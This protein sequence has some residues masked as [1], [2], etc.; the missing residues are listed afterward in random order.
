MPSYVIPPDNRAVGTGNPPQDVNELSDME[1]LL[2]AVV[3]QWG[4]YPGNTTIPA[5]NAANVTALQALLGGSR[6]FSVVPPPSGDTSGVTDNA[7]WTTALASGGLVIVPDPGASQWYVTGNIPVPD[8]TVL[9]G[10][11][12]RANPVIKLVNSSGANCVFGSHGYLNGATSSGYP[13]I[14]R[15][16]SI[17]VNCANNSGVHGIILMTFRGW[18][19]HCYVLNAGGAA[20][21]FTDENSSGGTIGN[22]AVENRCTHNEAYWSSPAATSGQYGIWVADHSTGAVTDGYML[23]NIVGGPGDWGIYAQRA[24]GWWV[25]GNHVYSAQGSG[26]YF[27]ATWASAIHHNKVAAF[28]IAGAASTTYFGFDVRCLANSQPGTN[29]RP[30]HFGHNSATK[31]ESGDAASTVN[32]YFRARNDTGA[33]TATLTWDHNIAHQDKSGSGTSTAWLFDANGATL[34]LTNDGNIADGPNAVPVTSGTVNY[35]APSRFMMASAQSV[36]LGVSSS[37]GTA[38]NFTP[39]AFSLGFIPTSIAMVWGGSFSSDTV[40]AQIVATYSDGTTNTQT[41]GNITSAQT[42]SANDGLRYSLYKNGVYLTQLA[43]SAR[44]NQGS[45]SVTLSAEVCGFNAN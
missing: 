40:N 24:S 22:T 7:A 2:A 29:G 23:D 14:V 32:R 20:F 25:T 16:L 31:D 36:T 38:V 44:T 13:V 10:P 39:A 5:S 9:L 45:T 33:G 15:N 26:A 42:Q 28:G 35:R 17:D 4:G 3:A 37:Y 34:D 12:F 30:S 6:P 21:A 8:F 41:W 1:G 11:A 43:I 18:I 19:D 27:G